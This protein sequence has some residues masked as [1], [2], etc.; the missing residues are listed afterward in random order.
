MRKSS[1]GKFCLKISLLLAES[2]DSHQA[3]HLEDP[4]SV[5]TWAWSYRMVVRYL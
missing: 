3:Y 4:F 5:L 2:Q 1:E